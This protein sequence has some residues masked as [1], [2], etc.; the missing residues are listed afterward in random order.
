MF[1]T[2][3]AF[4]FAM[5]IYEVATKGREEASLIE[6]DQAPEIELTE[7]QKALARIEEQ[8][9]EQDA[10]PGPNNPW[11]EPS[12]PLIR[13]STLPGPCFGFW[14]T[15]WWGVGPSLPALSLTLTSVK[16]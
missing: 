4:Y 14:S 11:S 2:V 13:P 16:Q 15:H 7:T 9:A 3:V 6:V 8:D 1:L 10:F 5:Q 12:L